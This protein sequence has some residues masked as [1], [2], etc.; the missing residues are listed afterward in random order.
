MRASVKGRVCDHVGGVKRGGQKEDDLGSWHLS[1]CLWETRE[2]D[3]RKTRSSFSQ[4]LENAYLTAT[5]P[6]GGPKRSASEDMT[7]RV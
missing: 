4:S 2:E 5:E 7:E 1:L 6:Q 3:R